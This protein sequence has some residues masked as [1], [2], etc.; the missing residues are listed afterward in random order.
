MPHLKLQAPKVITGV[1]GIGSLV[2][3]A[4]GV[5]DLILLPLDQVSRKDGRIVY[6]LQQGVSSL[7]KTTAMEAIKLGSKLTAGLIRTTSYQSGTQ[8]W[9][10]HADEI[11]TGSSASSS[12]SSSKQTVSK[13]AQQPKDIFQG[14]GLAVESLSRH[15]S[16]AA[17]MVLALPMQVYDDPSGGQPGSSTSRSVIKAV[18]I[19]FI[20]P[21]IG[22]TEAITKALIGAQNSLDP[23]MQEKMEDKYK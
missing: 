9:L 8:V 11:F 21:L 20:K 6:G 7:A 3:I 18:P 2:N 10:E 19:A 23:T 14:A 16:Q 13:L 12:S 22:T 1:T 4:G 17:N 15:L 5:A